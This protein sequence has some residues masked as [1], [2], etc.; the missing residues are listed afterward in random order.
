MWLRWVPRQAPSAVNAWIPWTACG[1]VDSQV[2][3]HPPFAAGGVGGEVGYPEDDPMVRQ[4]GTDRRDGELGAPD[5]AFCA[6]FA[7]AFPAGVLTDR[8]NQ[9]GGLIDPSVSRVRTGL[10]N[11]LPSIPTT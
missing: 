6:G 9:P 1:E 10:S 5:E 7:V 3:E 11:T 4:R 8:A 2:G